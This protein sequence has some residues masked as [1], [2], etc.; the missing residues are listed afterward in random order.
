MSAYRA[1][2]SEDG[3]DVVVRRIDA[4]VDAPF[5]RMA[6]PAVCAWLGD[7]DLSDAVLQAGRLQPVDASRLA[8]WPRVV[9]RVLR[10]DGGEEAFC[11]QKSVQ[12]LGNKVD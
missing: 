8:L 2:F 11:A 10:P 1:T 9:T 12:S 4:C 6:A 5:H 7:G 3:L